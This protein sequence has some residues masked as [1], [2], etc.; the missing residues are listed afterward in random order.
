MTDA[1]FDPKRIEPAKT[2]GHPADEAANDFA[3]QLMMPEASFRQKVA[4]LNGNIFHL[5]QAFGVPEDAV[6]RRAAMLG[7][8]G[9]RLKDTTRWEV[10]H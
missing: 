1:I 3:A 8:T 10:K 2:D 4:E 9:H 6:R 7:M 5:A